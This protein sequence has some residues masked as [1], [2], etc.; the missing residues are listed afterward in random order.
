MN[1][2]TPKKPNKIKIF[3]A[4]TTSYIK[5]HTTVHLAADNQFFY[6]SNQSV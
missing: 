2:R 5:T 6:Q 1:D 4:F 3:N